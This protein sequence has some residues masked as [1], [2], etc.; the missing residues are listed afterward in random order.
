[1]NELP[2]S[3]SIRSFLILN[4]KVTVL[5]KTSGNSYSHEK[6]IYDR[7][8]RNFASFPVRT[9]LSDIFGMLERVHISLK[10][11]INIHNG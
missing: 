2:T 1:M 6:L 3:K 5:G 9:L 11:K 7:T 8:L 10:A 4:V